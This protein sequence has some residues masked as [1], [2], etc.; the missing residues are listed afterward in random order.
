MNEY[1]YIIDGGAISDGDVNILD[2]VALVSGI[3]GISILVIE[4]N[5]F[6]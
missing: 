6:M 1:S 5:N 4:S 3:L 2:F